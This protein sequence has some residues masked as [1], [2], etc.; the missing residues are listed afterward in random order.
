[1]EEERVD[2][3]W[4][5]F[6]VVQAGAVVKFRIEKSEGTKTLGSERVREETEARSNPSFLPRSARVTVNTQGARF[7]AFRGFLPSVA[8][9]IIRGFLEAFTL[10]GASRVT[11]TTRD[12]G[13][14]V[15]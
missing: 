11:V 1:M 4:W 14:C 3:A 15:T 2:G 6:S 9:N 5:S 8:A 13:A 10:G 12:S 7:R